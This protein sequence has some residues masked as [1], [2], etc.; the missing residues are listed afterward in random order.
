MANDEWL[1][2]LLK[3]ILFLINLLISLKEFA[4]I[5]KKNNRAEKLRV[6]PPLFKSDINHIYILNI[7][8]EKANSID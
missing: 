7:K 6:F 8:I 3:E 2:S 1:T 4:G 5:N